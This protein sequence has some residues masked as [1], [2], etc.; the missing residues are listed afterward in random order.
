MGLVVFPPATGF[1]ML[2]LALLP[3]AQAKILWFVII[4][5]T[6]V[7]GIRA[8]VR[9]AAPS[10]GPHAWMMIAGIILLSAAIRWGMMLLQG[11]PFVLGLLCFFVATLHKDR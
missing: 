6:L 3:F 7:L 5:L 9:V 4:N 1:A 10:I 8:L 2:P 11:A